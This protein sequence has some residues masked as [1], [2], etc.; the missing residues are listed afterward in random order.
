MPNGS[1][2]ILR[3]I[4]LAFIISSSIESYS[5][6]VLL[7]NLIISLFALVN[8][9]HL[10][11]CIKFKIIRS[12]DSCG[13]ALRFIVE[14][15]GIVYTITPVRSSNRAFPASLT[16]LSCFTSCFN[17]LT[18]AVNTGSLPEPTFLI[19]AEMVSP[20]RFRFN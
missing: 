13:S 18:S 14:P 8:C 15:G 4:L 10:I 11:V 20:R 2:F 9:D 3:N 6:L 19:L 5:L 1:R 12:A 16:S 17:F 7:I